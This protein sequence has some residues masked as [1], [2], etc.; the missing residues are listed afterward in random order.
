MGTFTIIPD[1][2]AY[3]SGAGIVVGGTGVTLVGSVSDASPASWVVDSSA[4]IAGT[5]GWGFTTNLIPSG[6]RVKQIAVSVRVGGTGSGNCRFRIGTPSPSIPGAYDYSGY[7][8]AAVIA[9]SDYTQV[10]A[11]LST[12]TGSA[13]YQARVDGLIVETTLSKSTVR[14]LDISAQVL[15]DL[16]P[17]VA[18]LTPVTGSTVGDD[19]RPLITWSYTD[20]IE[21]QHSYQVTVYNS[22]SELVGGVGETVGTEQGWL[23]PTPLADDTYTVGVRASQVW[24]GALGTFW[25]DWAY[26]TFTLTTLPVAAPTADIV[27]QDARGRVQ[28]RVAHN[29]NLLPHDAAS[30]ENGV[31]YWTDQTTNGTVTVD[32]TQAYGTHAKSLK[33]VRGSTSATQVGV[34]ATRVPAGSSLRYEARVRVKADSSAASTNVLVSLVFVAADTTTVI[35]TVTHTQPAGTGWDAAVVTAVSPPGTAYVALTVG[36]TGTQLTHRIGEAQLD[37]ASDVPDALTDNALSD[38][39]NFTGWLET[40]GIAGKGYIGEYAWDDNLLGDSA[41]WNVLGQT[42]F[43]HLNA[44]GLWA[45]AWAVGETWPLEGTTTGFFN[46]DPFRVSTK[47]LGDPINSTNT[48][49][50]VIEANGSATSWKAYRRGVNVAGGEFNAPP[51]VNDGTA[52]TWRAGYTG[53]EGIT[54]QQHH[55]M[56]SA[57]SWAYLAAHGVDV[58][59]VPFR[60]ER[61]QPVLG[62][63]LGGD[64]TRLDA[65]IA[66][67]NTAGIVCILDCHN[68]GIYYDDNAGAQLLRFVGGDAYNEIPYATFSDFWSKMSTRYKTNAGVIGYGL[69]NEPAYIT[70]LQWRT[71]SQGALDA[72]RA[73]GDTKAV[74]VC[75]GGAEFSAAK[76]WSVYNPVPWIVDGANNYFYEA[77]AYFFDTNSASYAVVNAASQA[78]AFQP[79]KS[80]VTGW[81]PGGMFAA[82]GGSLITDDDSSFEQGLG[83]WRAGNGH[84]AIS[85]TFADAVHGL[86]AMKVLSVVA[87]DDLTVFVGGV[88]NYIP[89]S[90]STLYWGHVK[91]NSQANGRDCYYVADWYDSVGAYISTSVA[92]RVSTVGSWVSVSGSFTSPAGAAFVQVHIGILGCVVGEYHFVDCVDLYTSPYDLGWVRGDQGY[93]DTALIM[94]WSEDGEISFYPSTADHPEGVA[95]LTF[96]RLAPYVT[97]EDYE[98]PSLDAADPASVLN[99]T[100]YWI[101]RSQ[102]TKGITS[103]ASADVN[104]GSA[105]QRL[106]G[107]W[108]ATVADPA[109]TGHMFQ[110]ETGKQEAISLEKT[111]RAFSGR[112]YPVIE[113]GTQQNFQIAC[114][115]QLPDPVD[116]V[117]LRNLAIVFDRIIYRDRRGRRFRG[118]LD[119]VS[120]TDVKWGHIATF[121]VLVSGDQP[122]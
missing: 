119:G 72:I 107:L 34:R 61:V 91:I 7:T 106:Q 55:Y 18:V 30:F 80:A 56:T 52:S 99:S 14:V 48:Q 95:S 117:A 10:T 77:H 42:W 100:R 75:G 108:L 36:W 89:V 65:M 49:A 24:T 63:A 79:W 92:N 93:G 46:H 84:T 16:Q 90:P 68:Y 118:V 58:V 29:L 25:A 37:F 9:G 105:T 85:V 57:T 111:S 60:W 103:Q 86:A 109:S 94:R 21:A 2:V 28:I 11:Y 1:S 22:A 70:T 41:A 12:P 32:G 45:T 31:S 69:M 74:M 122:R 13:W 78:A 71:A 3:S 98:N 66:A 17:V 59:R 4:T 81:T 87:N 110:Y 67:A 51:F 27:A 113:F 6:S 38:L 20:D 102:V 104:L 19:S 76:T 64:I 112:S 40:H 54:D 33:V 8:T 43:D 120:I 116:I 115:V 5:V 44:A 73:T 35:Q 23:P 15:Y 82:P 97:Y 101:G 50:A 26:S 47:V 53:T 114:S 62:G 121:T 88:N 83:S 96:S 39:A